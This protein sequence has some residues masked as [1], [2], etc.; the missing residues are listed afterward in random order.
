MKNV[1]TLAWKDIKLF[2]AD[3]K[4]MMISFAVPITIALFFGFIMGGSADAT[5]PAQKIKF[6]V[7]DQDNSDVTQGITA[8]LQKSKMVEPEVVDETV[9]REQVKTGKMGVAIF[10]PKGFGKDAKAALFAGTPPKLTMLYDPSKKTDMSMVQGAFMQSAM[11]KISQGAFSGEG[12]TENLGKWRDSVTDPAQRKIIES[13]MKDFQAVPSGD[14]GSAAPAMQTPF[15]VVETAAAAPN[16]GDENQGMRGHIFGGMAMQGVLF[17]AIESAMLMLRDRRTGVWRRL[18]AAPLSRLAIILGRLLSAAMISASIGLGVY[19]S[20]MLLMG[21]RVQGSW[22]GFFLILAAASVMTAAFGLLVASLGKTEA[23]SRGFAILAVLMMSML[24]GAWF[25]TFLMPKFVQT[26][27][28]AIPVRWATDG[29]D[30]VT[31]RGLGA[32]S[33]LV[34]SAAL[35]GFAAVFGAIA[36]ARFRW[37]E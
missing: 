8:D 24:G 28:L 10:F 25:P 16:S 36:V 7:V 13:L 12:A 34:S 20:G 6:L 18:R 1:W 4:S 3:R 35:L 5:Q 9:A 21:V 32:G 29:F 17:F 37:E 26:L 19:L 22:P 14:N 27:S 11:S 15:E 31:W 2:M 33:A 23:Q 30:A